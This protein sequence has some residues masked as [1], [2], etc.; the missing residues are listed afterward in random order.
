MYSSGRISFSQLDNIVKG[1]LFELFCYRSCDSSH[2]W[3]V[4]LVHSLTFRRHRREFCHSR[5]RFQLQ[6][7]SHSSDHGCAYWFCWHIAYYPLSYL[8]PSL[9]QLVYIPPLQRCVLF[10]EFSV[11]ST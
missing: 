9:S 8:T 1:I 2:R 6:F 11:A 3:T 10:G 7:V 4:D 5:H